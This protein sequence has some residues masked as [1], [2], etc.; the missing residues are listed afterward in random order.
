MNKSFTPP[1]IAN[2]SSS[3]LR[4]FH[5]SMSTVKLVDKALQ[6]YALH[7]P[8]AERTDWEGRRDKYV[9]DRL[10]EAGDHLY[11][12][13]GRLYVDIALQSLELAF[14]LEVEEGDSIPE[15]CEFA[16]FLHRLLTLDLELYVSKTKELQ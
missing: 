12:Y 11:G 8:W 1:T 10:F 15:D 9:Q 14:S 16:A 5:N 4:G 13:G 6:S 7:A 2:A 3:W